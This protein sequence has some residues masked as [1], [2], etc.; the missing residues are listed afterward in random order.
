ME[1]PVLLLQV[2]LV[3]AVYAAS[4]YFPSIKTLQHAV[5]FGLWQRNDGM[6]AYEPKKLLEK[7]HSNR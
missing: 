1:I 6:R 4:A 5:P 7:L 3:A 2:T